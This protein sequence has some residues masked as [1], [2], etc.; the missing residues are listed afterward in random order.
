MISVKLYGRYYNIECKEGE[1]PKNAL[2]R[3]VA[4]KRLGQSFSGPHEAKKHLPK[5]K[6]SAEKIKEE[7]KAEVKEETKEQ[8]VEIKAKEKDI[9]ED[10]K[11]SILQKALLLSEQKNFLTQSTQMSSHIQALLRILRFIQRFW[12]EATK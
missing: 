6:V 4:L 7:P 3:A 11:M 5:K 8:P 10:V 2:E 1:N 12:N 9:M